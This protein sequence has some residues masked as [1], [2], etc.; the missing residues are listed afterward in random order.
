[1][2]V[3]FQPQKLQCFHPLDEGQ[4]ATLPLADIVSVSEPRNLVQDV[5]NAFVFLALGRL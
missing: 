2:S 4:V 5:T 1:M 3:L